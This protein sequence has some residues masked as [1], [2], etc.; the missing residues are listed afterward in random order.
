MPNSD[1]LLT[2]AQVAARIPVH[3]ETVRRW[4]REG[5]LTAVVLPSGRKRY[6]AADVDALLL[7]PQDAA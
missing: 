2:A 5:K 6:R 7:T 4:T 3:V 1:P